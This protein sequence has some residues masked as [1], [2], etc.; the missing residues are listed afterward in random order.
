MASI[1]SSPECCVVST[2]AAELKCC[3]LRR[4]I[5]LQDLNL[6]VERDR[7]ICSLQRSKREAEIQ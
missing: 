3:D 1:S 4:L 2:L 6:Q 5:D 7:I